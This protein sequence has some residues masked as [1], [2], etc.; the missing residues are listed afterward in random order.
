MYHKIIF[1]LI[2]SSQGNGDEL[3]GL[4]TPLGMETVVCC[5]GGASP[6][7]IS[8]LGCTNCGGMP[9]GSGSITIRI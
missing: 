7:L 5:L 2:S 9:K 3:I 1:L 4:C 8:S 6:H